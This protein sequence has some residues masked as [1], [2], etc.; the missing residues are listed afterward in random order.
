MVKIYCIEDINDLKYVGSTK[1]TLKRRL[2]AH[3][4]HIK[5]IKQRQCSSIKLNLDNCIIYELEETDEEHRLEK[6][7][8]WIHKIDCVNERKYDFDKKEYE[9]EYREKNIDKIKEKVKQYYKQNR[10]ELKEKEKQRH[11]YRNSWGGD[12]RYNNNLLLID[13]SIFL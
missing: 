3:R 8:Y 1:L 2:C 6:E 9:K 4:K 5:N 11:H 7:K 12:K 13:L 10:D